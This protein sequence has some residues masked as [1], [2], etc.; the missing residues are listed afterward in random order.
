MPEVGRHLL[1]RGGVIGVFIQ[2]RANVAIGPLGNARWR[3][4]LRIRRGIGYGFPG[5]A[6]ASVGATGNCCTGVEA[7]PSRAA[8]FEWLTTSPAQTANSNPSTV[9][10]KR[11]SVRRRRASLAMAATASGATG[12]P[13]AAQKRCPVANFPQCEQYGISSSDYRMQFASLSHFLS[14]DPVSGI[15]GGKP[16]RSKR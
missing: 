7:W 9:A 11:I 16:S 4:G 15:R 13:Q 5:E 14:S 2:L 3:V 1:P 12:A 10:I 8:C 6:P